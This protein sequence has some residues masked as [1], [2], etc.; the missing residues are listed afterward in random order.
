MIRTGAAKTFE[1]F[2]A[3]RRPTRYLPMIR[4]GAENSN[5]SCW[6]PLGPRECDRGRSSEPR[7]HESVTGVG[8]DD[9]GGREMLVGDDGW[10]MMMDEGDAGGG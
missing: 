6:P 7:G 10:E 1:D 2:E 3:K 9:V 4:T 8:A 5:A